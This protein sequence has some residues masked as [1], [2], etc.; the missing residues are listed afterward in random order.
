M[1]KLRGD[2]GCEGKVVPDWVEDIKTREQG[3]CILLPKFQREDM[4]STPG[5]LRTRRRHDAGVRLTAVGRLEMRW[6]GRLGDVGY[7]DVR[8]G[9]RHLHVDG[10]LRRCHSRRLGDGPAVGLVG[11]IQHAI[12]SACV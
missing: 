3:G 8:Y 6:A 4:T 11:E 1:R 9:S 12:H 7:G 10:M 2:V 5:Q